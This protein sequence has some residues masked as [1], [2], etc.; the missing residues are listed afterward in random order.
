MDRKNLRLL[1]KHLRV[2]EREVEYQLKTQTDCC[3]VTPAQCHVLLELS[4]AGETSL[5]ELAERLKLDASTLSRTVDSLVRLGHL[6]RLPDP[7]NRRSV[8]LTLTREGK[9]KADFIDQCCDRLYQGLLLQVPKNKQSALVGTVGLLAEI[10]G[11]MRDPACCLVKIAPTGTARS[12]QRPQPIE[13][14]SS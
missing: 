3:G 8:R 1:R 12:S 13:S 6:N 5:N 10:L 7:Q 14:R 2:I 11:R 9:D 4:E